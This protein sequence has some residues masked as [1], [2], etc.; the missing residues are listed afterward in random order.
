LRTRALPLGLL[1]DTQDV[2]AAFHG[3]RRQTLSPR[4]AILA[5]GGAALFGGLGLAVLTAQSRATAQGT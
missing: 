5:G 4:G 2:I 1:G 3:I